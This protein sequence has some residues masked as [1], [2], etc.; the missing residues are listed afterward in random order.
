[1]G[2]FVLTLLVLGATWL[3]SNPYQRRGL[4]PASPPSHPRPPEQH[5]QQVEGQ[6][7][8]NFM[9]IPTTTDDDWDP[10]KERSKT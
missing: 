3:L 7:N 6:M 10:S 9:P 8:T 1:M 2:G 4:P 5:R